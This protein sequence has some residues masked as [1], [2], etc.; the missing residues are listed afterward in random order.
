MYPAERREVLLD[1][2]NQK[3]FVSIRDLAVELRVSEITIRR[4]LKDLQRQGLVE[5][6]AGGGQAVR[7]ASELPFLNKRVLQQAEKARIAQRAL[8]LIEPG[9]TIGLSAGTTTW[10][11]AQL[12]RPTQLCNLTFV[13]NST[14]VAIALQTNGWTDIHL[15]GGQFRTPSDALVGPLAEENVRRLYT[16]VL[17]L[18]AHGVHLDYG[19]ST[20]N[21]LE[22]SMH[23]V[24]MDRAN[25]VV[26]LFDH[27]KWG[28]RALAHLAMVDEVDIVITDEGP[29]KDE[30]R[31]DNLGA[32]TYPRNHHHD[33]EIAQLKRLGLEVFVV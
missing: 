20:P 22:A 25:T 10:T 28:I 27:T 1:L 31:V 3:G 6:V 24:M 7:S 9:M 21:I 26:L 14:N 19:L 17:F 15:T 32:E 23:R 2:L 12:I 18:G 5:K 30:D 13:T 11:L 8:S 4:D 16:D 33:E 29:R